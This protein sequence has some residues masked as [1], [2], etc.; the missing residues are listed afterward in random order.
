MTSSRAA[1]HPTN[2]AL[3]SFRDKFTASEHFA[4]LYREGMTLVEETAEYLDRAGRQEARQLAAR[5]ASPI[6]PKA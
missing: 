2:G 4:K 6:H 5:P 3:L 1:E